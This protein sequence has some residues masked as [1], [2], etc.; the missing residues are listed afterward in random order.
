MKSVNSV[1]EYVNLKVTNKLLAEENA[2]LRSLLPG[3]FYQAGTIKIS[4]NDSLTR[5]HYSYFTAKVINNSIIRRNNYLTLDKGSLQGVQP[6]MGIISSNGVVGIVKN[7]SEHYCTVMSLLNKDTRVSAKF[8]NNNYFGSFLWE[9]V[10]PTIGTLKDVAKHVTFKTG[11]TI[12]TTSYSLVFPENILIGT[13]LNSE[14]K[15][16]DNFYTIHVKLS[17]DFSN[18]T[19]VYIVNNVFKNEQQKLEEDA[20]SNDH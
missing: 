16:G 14:L 7:V 12:V 13:V 2:R 5:Q 10:N 9:G 8:K 15:P 11:D 1:N 18:L 19:Y 20:L 6:E 4:V 3:A 17:V